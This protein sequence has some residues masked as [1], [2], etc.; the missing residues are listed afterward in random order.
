VKLAV[1]I[2]TSDG[3]KIPVSDPAPT[4]AFAQ[5]SVEF[6][7]AKSQTGRQCEAFN[8]DFSFTETVD[9]EAEFVTLRY[10]ELFP[11][12][13]RRRNQAREPAPYTSSVPVTPISQDVL[14]FPFQTESG[15]YKAA[16]SSQWP[17]APPGRPEIG[18]ADTGTR[19]SARF[20]NVQSGVQVWVPR[21]VTSGDLAIRLAS[22]EPG[23]AAYVRV[24]LTPNA[25]GENT[26]KAAWEVL[27]SNPGQIEAADI[28]VIYTWAA[29][30]PNN[31]PS[32][33]TS[34]ING[35]LQ[36]LGM[37]EPRQTIP[38]FADE[39]AGAPGR[40]SDASLTIADCAQQG[41][42]PRLAVTTGAL[43]VVYS[44]QGNLPDPFQFYVL[45]AGAEINGVN[46]ENT[47]PWLRIEKNVDVTPV[48]L[49]IAADP[50][51]LAPG[52]YSGQ[53]RITGNGFSPATVTIPLTVNAP[54]PHVTR[55][56]VT[57]TASYDPNSVS[58][59]AALTIFGD[60]FGPDE[61]VTAQFDGGRFA[62]TLGET[63][64][65][66]D[67]IAAPMIYAAKG[68]VSAIAPFAL[69]GKESTV[70]EVEHRGVK[71][72]GVRF[73][74]APASPGLLTADASG[75]GQAAALNEDNSFNS[76]VGAAPGTYVVVFGVGGPKMDQAGR[77]GE[78]TVAPLPKFLDPV[79]VLLNGVEVPAEDVAYVGPAPG[80]VQGVWQANVRL[81]ANAPPNSKIEIQLRFGEYMTQPGV[82]VSVR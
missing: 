13:F 73:A 11:S 1:S 65:L 19:L 55:W 76:Q 3:T 42:A 18:L 75:S 34:S 69:E 45:S 51:A 25:A 28:N 35:G 50:S 56:G 53:F 52:S 71:S 39:T 48:T 77:D 9:P 49:R 5:K 38:R 29:G 16:T 61:L 7:V 78:L 54:G 64:V 2:T 33:G 24:P 66:F 6:S 58:A 4:V 67:G 30:M 15:F 20:Y 63:R 82:V 10:R 21:V 36:P 70:V 23:N 8:E 59:G 31:L 46:F 32:T 79:T 43:P 68:Q 72:P 60:R 41:Q 14:G 40:R 57:N 37:F 47:T 44:Q 17:A 27:N 62:T 81:A 26:G 12:A 80:L 22:Q 74:V